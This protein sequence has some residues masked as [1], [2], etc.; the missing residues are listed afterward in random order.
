[1]KKYLKLLFPLTFIAVLFNACNKEGTGYVAVNY[2]YYFGDSV[3]KSDVKY[4]F[5]SGGKK[6]QFRVDVM[7]MYVARTSAVNAAN[8]ATELKDVALFNYKNGSSLLVMD[9]TPSGDYAS[10]KF[11]L[12]LDT[13]LNNSSPSSFPISHPLST[14]QSMY[15]GMLK[16]RFVVMEGIIH[17][18]TGKEI[19]SVSYHTGVD[20]SRV[21]TITQAFKVS[22]NQTTNISVK[23]NLEKVFTAT[24]NN[25]D[26][27]TETFTHSS[28]GVEYTLAK[29]VMDNLASGTTITIN[30]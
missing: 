20:L 19:G 3:L 23:F 24:G 6:Y 27:T 12:G 1:M 28:P 2:A 9:T 16:Y 4:N 29:K 14:A 7:K 21:K 11:T 18:S 30:P 26:P 8:T 5:V 17:D 22:D 25:I 13:V 10:F 15:W